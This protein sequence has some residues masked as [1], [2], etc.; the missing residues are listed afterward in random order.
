MRRPLT[1]IVALLLLLV[2]VRATAAPQKE[3]LRVLLVGSSSMKGALGNVLESSLSQWSDVEVYR[4]GV[5]SSGL[6][7]PDFFDWVAEIERL[8]DEI[9]PHVVI[10]NLGANDAQGV[11]TPRGWVHWGHPAWRDTYGD[12]VEAILDATRGRR[13]FWVGP[14]NMR[15]AVFSRRLADISSLIEKHVAAHEHARFVDAYSLTSDEA[16]KYVEEFVDFQGGTVTSR[17]V[18]GIHFTRR[19]A[20]LIAAKILSPLAAEVRDARQAA[21]DS[22]PGW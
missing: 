3:P 13:V 11:W 2:A 9:Q 20:F 8:K 14:P 15:S 4:Q 19:G 1:Q 18:D 17:T 10:I 16:G 22:E 7:R 12:R 5:G 6:A 21:P